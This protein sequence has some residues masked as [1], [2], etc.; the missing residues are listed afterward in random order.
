MLPAEPSIV[1]DIANGLSSSVVLSGTG[2]PIPAP[3]I[4]LSSSSLTFSPTTVNTH[5]TGQPVTLTNSGNAPLHVSS[6]VISGASSGDFTTTNNCPSPLAPGA[7]CTLS[8]SFTPSTAGARSSS[9][10][11]ASDAA[12]SPSL[13]TLTGTGTSI[14]TNIL[15]PGANADIAFT[16]GSGTIARDSSGHGND[17]TFAAGSNAP[18]WTA[19]GM[20]LN[21]AS[22][23][24]QKYCTLPASTTN[25]DSS[26][27]NS[28]TLTM[29]A[30]FHPY[31]SG[32][33]PDLAIA[34]G[35]SNRQDI[36]ALLLSGRAESRNAYYMGDYFG[37]GGEPTYTHQPLVGY[38]CVTYALGSYT[39]GTPDHFYID[40]AEVTSYAAQGTVWDKRAAGDQY[41]VGALPW[42]STGYLWGTVYYVLAYPTQ[43]TAASVAQNFSILQQT[44][45]FNRGVGALPVQ[46]TTTDNILV[47]DGD[48]I[49]AGTAGFGAPY[50]FR[51][52][53][54]QPFTIIDTAV[55]GK[56]L[57]TTVADTPL[58]DLPLYSPNARYA[59]AS[60]AA[61]INDLNV[62]GASGADVVRNRT[63]EYAAYKTKGFTVLAS[64]ML[65][66]VHD[67]AVIEDI[68]GALRTLAASSGYPL[69]DWANEPCLGAAGAYAN[70]A[71]CTFFQADGLHPN[72]TGETELAALYSN[73]VN[74]LTG[75]TPASPTVV[76]A[77]AYT[78]A[79][80]DHFLSAQGTGSQQL[81]L[82]SCYGWSITTPFTIT[83]AN[84]A[85]TLTLAPTGGFTLDG[86]STPIS[87]A[88]GTTLQVYADILSPTTSGCA[89][90]TK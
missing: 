13:V 58:I 81:S 72:P 25:A 45:F 12:V 17:C 73:V 21:D 77:P 33:I 67:D 41:W 83:N 75:S 53:L 16:E 86:G 40:G 35:G 85:G 1:T 66:S 42:G 59:F 68:N 49:T 14:P 44:A 39:D 43:L 9:L 34:F 27:M 80:A 54:N 50:P 15:I 76:T 56:L 5:S 88:S 37:Y 46:S 63:V 48:S 6:I 52:S 51:L 60:N 64:T 7:A 24:L 23:L 90:H 11:I 19:Q 71:G 29:C 8:V 38:H 10:E 30:Y 20:Q 2:T 89:W 69:V 82:P 70:P 26:V 18:T 31:T 55:G 84:T 4:A 3:G 65:S 28:R 87:I 62:A 61:G 79:P 57:E 22:D 47:M 74:Y 32:Q 36:G 78:I